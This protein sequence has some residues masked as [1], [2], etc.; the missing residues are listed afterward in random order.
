LFLLHF[1]TVGF[2]FA[3]FCTYW[4]FLIFF[5]L[6]AQLDF[7]K[8]HEFGTDCLGLV[9]K[10]ATVETVL[11]VTVVKVVTVGTI[12]TDSSDKI[13]FPLRI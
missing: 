6:S 10:V 2:F 11:T 5:V 3:P 9:V 1:G 7:I 12:V 8:L 4:V 13:L